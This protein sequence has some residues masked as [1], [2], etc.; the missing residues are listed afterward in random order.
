MNG[1][2]GIDD[3]KS[4]KKKDQMQTRTEQVS[5]VACQVV[6]ARLVHPF[7]TNSYRYI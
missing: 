4:G 5:G 1:S 6:L 7:L 3:S 2:L